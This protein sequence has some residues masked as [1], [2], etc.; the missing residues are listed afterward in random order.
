MFSKKNLCVPL[1]AL[2]MGLNLIEASGPGTGMPI[3]LRIRKHD[4]SMGRIQITD[5]DSTTLSSVLRTF[6]P[7][8]ESP[9]SDDAETEAN[10]ECTI[11][12]DKITDTNQPISA[13]GLKNG[14]LISIIPPKMSLSEKCEAKKVDVTTPRY[15]DFDPFPDLAKSSHSAAARRS[16]ALSRL[17]NKRSMSYGDIA[18]LHSFLHVIEPQPNGPIKRVYMCHVGAQKFRDNCYLQP[19]KKQL[20]AT[21]GKAK[22]QIR[23]KCALLFGTVNKERVDQSAMKTRTSLSTPL[24]EMKMCEVVKVHAVWEPP[25]KGSNEECYDAKKF[26][27]GKEVERAKEVAKALGMK[28]VGWIY[29]YSDDRQGDSVDGAAAASGED[30]LPV[31][32]RDIVVG[33]QGQIENMQQLGRDEGCKYVTLALDCKSGATEAFQLSNTSV[34]MVAEG[35]LAIPKDKVMERFVQTQESVSID[36]KETTDLDTVFCLVNTAMLSHEGRFSGKAGVNAVKKTGGLTNKKKKTLLSK[37][38]GES[39]EE[40]FREL[41]DFDT[42]MALHSILGKDDMDQLCT[43]VTKFSRGQR[44][45]TE[46][47][48]DL[49]LVLKSVLAS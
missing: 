3:I 39:N 12:K 41:C 34:Q 13:F 10:I 36:N 5:Q 27:K 31:W 42:L 32:G 21:K 8:S 2:N 7:D 1:L 11:G 16:R 17:P 46:M 29:S 45:G 23:N 26:V 19:T 33:A 38:E 24:Y 48:N 20:K 25:Q 40:I 44:K 22:V 4:G 18:N 6:Q 30:S 15:T 43:L 28:P 35:V 49:K 14:A 47:G 9:P 37:L